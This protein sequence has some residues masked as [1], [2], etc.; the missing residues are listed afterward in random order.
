MVKDV[1]SRRNHVPVVRGPDFVF[2]PAPEDVLTPLRARLLLVEYLKAGYC[3]CCGEP[4][5]FHRS[6]DL[7]RCE[8]VLR[9]WLGDAG[10]FGQAVEQLV[11]DGVV[12]YEAPFRRLAVPVDRSFVIGLLRSR[13]R[14]VR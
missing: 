3:P 8:P 13:T 5:P 9:A 6:S 14:R 10:A 1:R 2:E 4:I 11:D 12:V 7:P